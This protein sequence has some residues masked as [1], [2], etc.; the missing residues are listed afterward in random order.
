[1]QREEIKMNNS[2]WS[3]RV[4]ALLQA[5]LIESELRHFMNENTCDSSVKQLLELVYKQNKNV[6]NALKSITLSVVNEREV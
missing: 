3:N 2:N 1:M 5:Q 4:D 6:L